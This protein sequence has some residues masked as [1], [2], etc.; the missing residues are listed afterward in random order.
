ML[1][2]ARPQGG[3]CPSRTDRLLGTERI[4]PG[5]PEFELQPTRIDSIYRLLELHH[6]LA[7]QFLLDA[8]NDS[9]QVVLLVDIIEV[10]SSDG[11]DGTQVKTG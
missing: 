6:F 10:I 1:R 5:K 11:K 3:L 7:R 8:L 4:K 2:I 9:I